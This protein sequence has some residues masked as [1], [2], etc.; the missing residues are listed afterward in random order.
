MQASPIAVKSHQNKTCNWLLWVS[1]SIPGYYT[2][3]A[4]FDPLPC[5][6]S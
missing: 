5:A 4:S 6:M 1:G 3:K 2:H